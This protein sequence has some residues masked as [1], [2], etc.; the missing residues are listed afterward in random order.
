MHTGTFFNTNS[1]Q[2][3]IIENNCLSDGVQTMIYIYLESSK[4]VTKTKNYN[5]IVKF[6]Q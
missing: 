5:V 4:H 2:Y 3:Q 1:R 6:K